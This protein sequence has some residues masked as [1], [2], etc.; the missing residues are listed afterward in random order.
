MRK[1]PIDKEIPMAKIVGRLQKQ[2]EKNTAF[3]KSTGKSHFSPTL[4]AK[5]TDIAMWCD[6]GKNEDQLLAMVGGGVS[7]EELKSFLA[8]NNL[9]IKQSK[10]K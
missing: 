8:A 2:A 6:Q 10:K 7:R 3:E 5:R 9:T 1:G 4:R